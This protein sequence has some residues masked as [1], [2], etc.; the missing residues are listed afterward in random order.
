MALTVSA[1]AP[2]EFPD[3]NIP[4]MVAWYVT[5]AAA[6]PVAIDVVSAEYGFPQLTGHW[7]VAHL[8][9]KSVMLVRVGSIGG[10]A[11]HALASYGVG[12]IVLVDPDRLL[13][14]NVVRH[15]SSVKHVGRLKVD[16][17]KQELAEAWPATHVDALPVDVIAPA[18]L[19]RPR[20]RDVGVV[21]CTAD[22]VA[23]RRVV[24][25][26]AR[27]ARTDAVL[28][29]VL[30]DGAVGEI[31][32]LR[33]WADHGCLTC[34]RE[35]LVARGAVDPEPAL[36]LGYGTGTAHRP[37][38]AVG[39][40]LH[41]VGQMA[42]KAAVATV[43]ERKGHSDQKLPG[44]HAIFGLRPTLGWTPP[45]DLNRNGDIRWLP[46]SPPR[47]GCPTCEEP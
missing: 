6:R 30:Q 32:R 1:E 36:D 45:F 41:L 8:E 15:V 22:G 44:E 20:L 28:A 40:D 17:V 46:H 26:L 3:I 23:A 7:P 31:I 12:R 2:A 39:G 43:L 11:A 38:T 37:M 16:A 5:P 10:A 34:R 29:C 13:S 33:P 47:P 25:H 19:I 18:H 21:L 27:R 9:E 24:S 14:H 4:E 35:A 42:A